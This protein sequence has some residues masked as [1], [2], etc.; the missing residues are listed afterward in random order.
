MILQV[1]C[2]PGLEKVV[3]AEL[4]ALGHRPKAVGPGLLSIEGSPLDAARAC[5]MLR[6]ATT[7]RA[8][9]VQAEVRGQGD[10]RNALGSGELPRWLPPG[11][12]ISLK[13]DLKRSWLRHSGVLKEALVA[14]LPDRPLDPAGLGLLVRLEGRSLTASLDLAGEPLHRRGWRREGGRA[15]LRETLA[16]GLLGLAGW[17]PEEALYDPMCGSGT[18]PIE[19]ARWSLGLAPGAERDF[20]LERLAV[21]EPFASEYDALTTITAPP[22]KVAPILASDAHRGA[23]GS[24]TRNATRAGVAG[25]VEVSHAA[26]PEVARP[27]CAPGLVICNAPYGRRIGED[28]GEVRAAHAALGAALRGPLEGWRLALLTRD[29]GLAKATGLTLKKAADLENG[30]LRVGVYLTR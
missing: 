5:L 29:E 6:S 23:V 28:R 9:L 22:R 13:V 2:A 3:E 19:A 17:K 12:S 11:S 30:G 10:L 1:V 26:L 21:F 25:V 4:R 15:P 16:C 14:A 8:L 24:T 20:A 7:L 27:D 18:I